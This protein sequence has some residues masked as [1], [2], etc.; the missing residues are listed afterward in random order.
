[1][2]FI[3]SNCIGNLNKI[4]II[5]K[6]KKYIKKD[7]I[8]LTNNELHDKNAIKETLFVLT[9]LKT[10]EINDIADNIYNLL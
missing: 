7:I 3:I 5:R 1:M 10:N 8:Y 4:I 9:K 2:K 6:Q